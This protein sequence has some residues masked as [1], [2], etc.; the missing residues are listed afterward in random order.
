MNNKIVTACLLSWLLSLS[1]TA[2]KKTKQESAIRMETTNSYKETDSIRYNIGEA[3]A[4]YDSSKAQTFM[5]IEPEGVIAYHPT[6]GFEGRAKRI[7]LYRQQLNAV[8]T[9]DTQSAQLTERQHTS[10][11]QGALRQSYTEA[12]SNKR[13]RPIWW[14]V[15]AGCCVMAAT[16]WW[17]Y[18]RTKKM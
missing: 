4:F 10:W 13:V 15:V 18:R 3:K 6:E 17:V 2:L 14:V 12:T 11:E 9:T 5:E 1:C 16:A 7:K 8:T